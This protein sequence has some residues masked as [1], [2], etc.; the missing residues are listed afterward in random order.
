MGLCTILGMEVEEQ[1]ETKEMNEGNQEEE[2][3]LEVWGRRQS[4]FPYR[5]GERE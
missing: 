2:L 3:N 4:I 5:L 1:E